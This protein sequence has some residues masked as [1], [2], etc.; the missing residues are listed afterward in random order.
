MSEEEAKVATATAVPAAEAGK[1]E[2]VMAQTVH[3]DSDPVVSAKEL[4]A[5]GAHYGHQAR[6]WN[7]AMKPYIYTK[8]NNL[9][10]IDLNKTAVLIQTAYLAL[11]KIVEEG[12]KVLFVGTK[13]IAKDIIVAEATRSGSFYASNRWLGGSLT[14]F[15]TIS[16]RIKLL[17]TLQDE[18]DE[19]LNEKLSKKDAIAKAKEIE[20]LNT[21]VGGIKEMRKI[22]NAIVIVD[23]KYEHNA[24]H[25]AKLLHIPTFGLVDTNCDPS[26]ITYPIAVNVDGPESVKL[27]VGILADAVVAGK[28]GEVQYAYKTGAEDK[29]TM[30][31][32]LPVQ[33]SLDDLRVIHSK[34]REDIFEAKRKGKKRRKKV[35]NKKFGRKFPPRP[36]QDHGTGARPSTTAGQTAT[37]PA[38]TVSAPAAKAPVAGPVTGTTGE[39]K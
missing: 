34:I 20:R 21:L 1:A 28:G 33:F 36:S 12:G 26:G 31:D 14:N 39:S 6:R 13:P 5:V 38:E 7:P 10:I 30:K 24:V 3:A 19:G 23:T 2:D 25:E 32:I 37:K 22:P 4:L 27:V 11:K 15:K 16:R 18:A 9:H 29:G 8:R 17:K 35:V